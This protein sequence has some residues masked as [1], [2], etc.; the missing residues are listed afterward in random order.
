MEIE[1]LG[2]LA[3]IAIIMIMALILGYAAN[4]L[5][6]PAMLGYLFAG[7]IIGPYSWSGLIGNIE[8]I[9]TLAKV[10]ISLLLFVVGLEFSPRK[11][12]SIWRVSAVGGSFEMMGM[13][14]LGT[15]AGLIL[16]WTITEA[17]LLGAM[18]MMSSTIVIIKILHETGQTDTMHGRLLIGMLIIEDIGAI[19]VITTISSF[20][21][22]EA[23]MLARFMP[24]IIGIILLVAVIYLG[25]WI[26]P[27]ILKAVSVTHSRELFLLTVFGICISVAVLSESFGLSLALG[28]FMAGV[29]LSESEQHLDIMGQITPVKEIFLIIFFVSMGMTI[30]PMHLM[31]NPIPVIVVLLVLVIG[32]IYVNFSAVKFLGY[33]PKTSVFVGLGMIPLGEFSFIIARIGVDNGLISDAVYS[34]VIA[35]ALISMVLAPYAFHS[36]A[37]IYTW[38]RGK[39]YL[40]TEEEEDKLDEDVDRHGQQSGKTHVVVLGSAEVVKASLDCMTHVGC[41]FTVVDYDPKKVQEMKDRGIDAIY[42]DVVNEEVLKWAGVDYANLIIVVVADPVDAETAV[43]ICRKRNPTAY[44]IARAHGDDEKAAIAEHADDVIISEEVAGKRMAWHVLRNLGYEEHAIKRD[45][46]IVEHDHMTQEEEDVSSS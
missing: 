21:G 44:I 34:S 40:K 42:G 45:I 6:Q 32:K 30:D 9:E 41:N 3:D 39:G 5:G 46:E 29:I 43:N 16:G 38:L 19:I 1:A 31:R 26:F 23:G 13:L 4:R 11:L 2:L 15:V 18:M 27:K 10:G 8:E 37:G 20:I 35:A 36:R 7:M 12:K 25:R 28:A 22:S 17:L 14:F 24:V 33:H